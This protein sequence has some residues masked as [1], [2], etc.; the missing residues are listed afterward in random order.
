MDVP[1]L[2][3]ANWSRALPLAAPCFFGHSSSTKT[4][5]WCRFLPRF[6]RDDTCGFLYGSRAVVFADCYAG[7]TLE[8]RL[9]FQTC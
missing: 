2:A 9:A 3:A 8:V 6:C 7:A 1:E 5:W 4:T